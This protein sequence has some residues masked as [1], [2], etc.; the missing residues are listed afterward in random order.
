LKDVAAHV[1]VHYSTVSRALDP[2]T[3]H[4]ITDEVRTRIQA[5]AVELNYRHNS[6][7]VSLR[8]NCSKTVG[9]IVP[10]ITNSLFGLIIKGIDSVCSK[11]DYVALIGNTDN[12][13]ENERK[14][15]GTF[16]ARGVEGLIVASA[17]REDEA[18][19]ALADDGTPIVTVNSHVDDDTVSSVGYNVRSSIGALVKHLVEL[20][21]RR[22]A[23]VSGP[24][25]W[26]TAEERL[27]A[28]KY[29]IERTKAV[30]SDDLIVYSEEYCEDEGA[31]CTELLLRSKVGFTALMGAN[32]LLAFGA[33][34]AL[35]RY[36][37]ECPAD[38]S[39]TGFNDIPM[40]RRWTPP[41]TTI[42]VDPFKAGREAAEILFSDMQLQPDK[43]SSKHVLLP[44]TPVIRHST[45]APR[46]RQAPPS[47]KR[48]RAG[49]DSAR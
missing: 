22:I 36:G 20:G 32:D 23:F 3:A 48:P 21:H 37:L 33:I 24:P 45:A 13:P 47:R 46:S 42:R 34:D 30:A 8:T 7:A 27:A 35:Q 18:I 2:A 31:R 9:I 40:A 28:Y 17:L 39:V 41:L 4:R 19:S 6:A 5:A 49:R 25:T 12:N 14:L 26:S 43:R 16:L 44:T 38:V 10:D 29:W 15:I 11:Q 1:G